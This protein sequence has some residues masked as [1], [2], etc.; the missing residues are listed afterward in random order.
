VEGLNEIRAREL[1]LER[2]TRA[3]DDY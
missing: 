2:T 1:F 3:N